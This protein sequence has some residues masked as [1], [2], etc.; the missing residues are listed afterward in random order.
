M[1]A[2]LS[3]NALALIFHQLRYPILLSW[4]L[5]TCCLATLVY[6]NHAVYK[7]LTPKKVQRI[8]L[9]PAGH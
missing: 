8:D 1:P 6:A 5:T 7:M 2:H 3:C 9:L 4:F